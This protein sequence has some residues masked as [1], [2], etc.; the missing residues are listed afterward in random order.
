MVGVTID[1]TFKKPKFYIFTYEEAFLVDD[2]HM[3]RFP[4]VQKKIH[5]FENKEAYRKAKES[6]PEYV[7]NYERYINENYREFLNKWSKIKIRT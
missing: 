3:K 1:E 7:T 2:V 4:N 6:K 5:L